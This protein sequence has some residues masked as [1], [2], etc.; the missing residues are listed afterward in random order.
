MG[1]FVHL[2]LHSE[3]SLLDGACRIAEIAKKAR[4]EGHTAV[5][6][7]DHGVL[8]GAVA[9][10]KA[11]K[12]EGIKPIIGCEV[13]VA[14]RTRFDKSF[15]EDASPNHLVLLCK[16][17][18]GYKNLIKMVSLGFTE[19]FYIKP[20]VD[21]EL[22]REYSEGLIAL[23]G[24]LSGKIQSLIADGMAGDA[25]KEAEELKDIFGD[26]FYLEIQDHGIDEQKRVNAV[27]RTFSDRLGVPLVATNDVHYLNKSD[28]DTQA[29]M[30]C[31]QTNT[32]LGEEHK[33]G[34]PTE[35]FYYKSTV[36]LTR[37]WR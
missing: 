17:E 35:E 34:F 16:N 2:H 23:S 36:S 37:V 8:Y 13:Y 32:K 27:L 21:K 5:A 12:T 6:I 28:S 33:I 15:T 26:D 24:C 14:S 7:T 18:T 11:C 29:V 4:S 10:Y 19:G 31:I 30:L 9:F 3:Y 1:D 22:L 25:Y 20:R